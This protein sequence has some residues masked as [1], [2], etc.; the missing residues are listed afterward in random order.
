MSAKNYENRLALVKVISEDGVGSFYWDT[1]YV[2]DNVNY[3]QDIGQSHVGDARCSI[4]MDRS[5]S[6]LVGSCLSVSCTAAFAAA[7]TDVHLSS[8]SFDY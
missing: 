4:G 5:F 7:A 3:R 8:N 1:V 6:T 2:T